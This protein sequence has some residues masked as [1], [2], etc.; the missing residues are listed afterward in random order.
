MATKESSRSEA[1]FIVLACDGIWDC[2]TSQEVVDFF[3]EE[4]VTDVDADVAGLCESLT[5]MIVAPRLQPIG[6]D[7]MT[8]MVVVLCHSG[9]EPEPDSLAARPKRRDGK[10]RQQQQQATATPSAPETAGAPAAAAAAAAAAAP[11][12]ALSAPSDA[13]SSDVRLV[14]LPVPAPF[15]GDLTP[16]AVTPLAR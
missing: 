8:L 5:R 10:Q 1:S 2:L 12:A 15:P 14:A 6:S 16:I 11:G 7:N 13:A 9:F 4:R 3:V